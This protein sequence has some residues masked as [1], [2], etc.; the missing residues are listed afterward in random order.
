VNKRL[1]VNTLKYLLAFGLL[2]YVV[3]S[4]WDPAKGRGLKHV[5]RA[6]FIEGQPVHYDYLAIA[7]VVFVASIL[8]TFIRWFYL[9]RAVE[10]PFR[11]G[12]ALRLGAIGYF[13]NTFLP[14]AVGGDIVKAAFLA[15]EHPERRTRA[16]ATVLIDRAIALWALVGFVAVL[17][18]GFWLS[19]MLTGAAERQCK[20]IVTAAASIVGG[21]VSVWVLL[22][23]LPPHRAE[24]FA[25]R[26]LRLPKV[27]AAASEFW[28]AVWMYRCRQESVGL[29]VVMS[30]VGHVGFV[31]TFYF[32]ALT[33]W[34]ADD[35]A[36][37]IPTLVEHFLIVPIGMVIG[38]V[39]LFPG[40]AG[41]GELGYQGLYKWL[42]CSE[43]SGVLGSLVQRVLSWVIGLL[44][45][46]VYVRMK[47]ALLAAE[48]ETGTQQ[49]LS[50]ETGGSNHHGNGQHSDDRGAQ[51]LSHRGPAI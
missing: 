20:T 27:G 37:N 33:L 25:G 15:R 7:F 18:C 21:S 19:G 47:P 6:H 17:G 11:P 45:F 8:L 4:N 49:G 32:C 12:D 30:W 46:G 16:V 28:R 9:V 5:W 3:I 50:A 40:G 38:A 26:L 29:A 1:L 51:S 24:R 34:D 39:P 41:I 23:F 48:E 43:S 22:G 14:G 44:G 42:G 10:L 31:L 35:P 36:Q 2:T 13:F